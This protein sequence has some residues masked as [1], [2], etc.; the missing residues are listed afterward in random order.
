MGMFFLNILFDLI[1][2]KFKNTGPGDFGLCDI[3]TYGLKAAI[4]LLVFVNLRASIDILSPLLIFVG[5]RKADYV[6][7]L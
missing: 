6:S 5:V 2:G 7:L 4:L 3:S 1:E